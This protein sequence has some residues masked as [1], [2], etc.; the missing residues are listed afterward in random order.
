MA[1]ATLCLARLFH[2]FNCRDNKSIF[3]IGL[4]SNKYSWMAFGVGLL[5]L[6]LVLL[7]P[8]MQNLFEVSTL[9]SSQV[10]YIYLFAFIPT[11]IIQVFKV[12]ID[13]INK[14]KSSKTNVN[15]DKNDISKVA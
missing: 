9:T 1:F 12:T 14:N 15:E 6:N 5:L 10:G 13:F 2:G 4:F 11:V 3:S 8:F 7:V